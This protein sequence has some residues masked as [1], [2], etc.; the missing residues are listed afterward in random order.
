MCSH[1]W[2]EVMH[3]GQEYKK[4]YCILLSESY[5]EV[6]DVDTMVTW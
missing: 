4:K 2:T 3:F 1:V 5:Q 6:H